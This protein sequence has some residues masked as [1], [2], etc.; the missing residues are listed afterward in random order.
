MPFLIAAFHSAFQILAGHSG[1][2]P[3]IPRCRLSPIPHGRL[4]GRVPAC[5]RR[6][7]RRRHLQA[8]RPR[9]RRAL[10]E[11]LR[12]GENR[13]TCFQRCLRTHE[14]GCALLSNLSAAER[15]RRAHMA[16][17]PAHARIPAPQARRSKFAGSKAL[18]ASWIAM[19]PHPETS[20]PPPP[21]RFVI[22]LTRRP[23]ETEP[24][25]APPPPQKSVIQ[26]D[27]MPCIICNAQ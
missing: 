19:A 6:R 23:T 10:R 9:R 14:N 8:V 2:P 12:G 25:P 21:R 5:R 17:A 15:C 27:G 18:C 3:S 22:A 7:P 24:A 11:A 26:R 1:L 20:L 4:A 13:P 16:P